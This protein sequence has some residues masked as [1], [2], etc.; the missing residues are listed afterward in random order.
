MKFLESEVYAAQ[1]IL[2][3]LR[4]E[5]WKSFAE[6]ED[7]ATKKKARK[8]MQSLDSALTLLQRTVSPF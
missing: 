8:N 1:R 7:P 5:N 2:I 6:T 4:E 3:S